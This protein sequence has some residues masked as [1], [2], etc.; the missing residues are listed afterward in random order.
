VLKLVAGLL[1]NIN[2]SLG[3]IQEYAQDWDDY[4]E[5]FHAQKG[6]STLNAY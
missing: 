5:Q 2:I 3:R 4:L 1:S 6:K